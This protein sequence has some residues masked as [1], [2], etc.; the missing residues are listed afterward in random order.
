[1]KKQKINEI[2]RMLC[3]E[4]IIVLANK[5]YP[6]IKKFNP[7]EKLDVYL[8]EATSLDMEIDIFDIEYL[9][10][11][12]EIPF[13]EIQ[14]ELLK[15]DNSSPKLDELEFIDELIKKYDT[16]RKTILTRIR[17]VRNINKIR[18]QQF[19]V[20][21]VPCRKPFIIAAEKAEAFKNSTNSREDNEFVRKMA[22]KF[23]INNLVEY[24][25]KVKKIG[26]KTDKK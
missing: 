22:E 7:K 1:M 5:K 13:H 14:S 9:S 15:Y 2:K 3:L 26:Q 18:K 16:D 24:K 4:K 10:Y 20:L 17:Q 23:R 25:V 11:A 6:E 19:T 21:A 12:A 8:E